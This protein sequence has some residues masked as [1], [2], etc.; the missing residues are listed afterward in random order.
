MLC[1]PEISVFDDS[2][3]GALAKEQILWLDVA[4]N[5]IFAVQEAQSFSYEGD[6][7]VMRKEG[8]KGSQASDGAHQVEI[9]ISL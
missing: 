6:K 3:V 7:R 8:G 4:M 1:K 2:I 9:K 5:N